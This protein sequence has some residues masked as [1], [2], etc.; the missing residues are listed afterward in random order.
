MC[1]LTFKTSPFTVA[2][3]READTGLIKRVST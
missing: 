1:V 3:S 2:E